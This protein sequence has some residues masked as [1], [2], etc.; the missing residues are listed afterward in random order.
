MVFV[1]VMMAIIA[2]LDLGL[3]RLAFAVFGGNSG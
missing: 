2:S 3:G 1:L